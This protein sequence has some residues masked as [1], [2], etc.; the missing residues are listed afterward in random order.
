MATKRGRSIRVVVVLTPV[1][2]CI[3]GLK[4]SKR[5]CD[6]NHVHKRGLVRCQSSGSILTRAR[7]S[8]QRGPLESESTGHATI[9]EQPRLGP[10]LRRFTSHNTAFTQPNSFCGFGSSQNTSAQSPNVFLAWPDSDTQAKHNDIFRDRSWLSRM[11]C[12]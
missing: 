8:F 10:A 12:L 3:S 1:H 7:A 11:Q 4:W 5:K 2:F 9:S 6:P